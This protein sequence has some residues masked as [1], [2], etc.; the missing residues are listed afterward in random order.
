[1]EKQDIKE[2]F[3]VLDTDKSGYID[4]SELRAGFASLGKLLDE[5]E[6]EAIFL[7][8]DKNNDG[9]ISLEEFSNCQH[10]FQK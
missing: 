8:I 10:Y 3:D 7:D 5:Q 6:C 1:M 4:R 9:Q 2:I